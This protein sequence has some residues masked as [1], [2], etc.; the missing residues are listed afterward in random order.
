MLTGTVKDRVVVREWEGG[1]GVEERESFNR[2]GRMGLSK[3][4]ER[5]GR[6][7][8]IMKCVENTSVIAEK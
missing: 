8:S 6:L 7:I 5:R 1:G 2:K 3:V 4:S